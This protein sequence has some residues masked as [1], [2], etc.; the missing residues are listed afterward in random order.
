MI[1]EI[2]VA[3]SPAGTAETNSERVASPT[4]RAA[5]PTEAPRSRALSAMTGRTAPAPTDQ[6]MDGPK[7]GT[8]IRRSENSSATRPSLRRLPAPFRVDLS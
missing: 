3:P 6:M 1:A 8:A 5:R 2:Q 4:K 7:A